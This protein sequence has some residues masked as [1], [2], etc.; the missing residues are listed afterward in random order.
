MFNDVKEK[1]GATIKAS[2][3]EAILV[4]GA[5]NARYLSGANLPF[6]HSFPDRPLAILWP[7][8]GSQ[9]CICP[10]EW[11][12][13]F[14]TMSWMDKTR[15]YAESPKETSIVADAAADLLKNL[16]VKKGKI[17]I[18]YEGI[19]IDLHGSPVEALAKF[20]VVPCDSLMRDL[21]LVKTPEELAHL[22]DV[23]YRADHAIFGTI[24]HVLVTS[25]RSEMSLSEEI[26]V[27]VM[28]RDLDVIGHNSVGPSASGE[29]AKKFWPL[30]PKFGMG[31]EKPLKPG[32]YVR[33]EVKTSLDGY[34]SDT[35][36]MM[37]MG[38]PTEGQS[39]SHRALRALNEAAISKIKPGAES[40]EVYSAVHE[41]ARELSV[42]LVPSLGVGHGVGVSPLEPPYLN[43]SDST[44]I[45]AGM[46]LVLSPMIYGPEGEIIVSKDTVVVTEDGCRVVGWYMDWRDPYVANWTL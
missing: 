37:T 41:K 1:I 39:A 42:D 12:S 36:R 32:E 20:E 26:R 5:D 7:K 27:H 46:V 4:F 14:L 13:T 24:H 35:A 18:D 40:R 43:A 17:G 2:G 15:R 16:G 6:L 30:A 22:E 33:V 21:R 11:E 29:H 23:A 3:L 34:W 38:E 10:V 28:E 45:K 19:S 25:T 44:T 9:V 8:D 31:F